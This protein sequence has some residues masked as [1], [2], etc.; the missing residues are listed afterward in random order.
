MRL[1]TLLTIALLA[2][3]ALA[4]AGEPAARPQLA[5]LDFEARNVD[6]LLA[7]SLTDAVAGALREL[8]VFKVV[9]QSEI[10]Q[11]L[12]LEH[13]R[14]LLTTCDDASCIAQIGA[15]VG[16]R[17]VVAGQV[18]ALEKNKGPLSLRLRLFDMKKAEVQS[19]ET[20][21]KLADAKEA[22]QAAPALALSSVRPILDKEQGFL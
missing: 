7:Q 10:R 18:V 21:S 4:T 16:A 2:A 6:P 20:R 17:F 12:A 3:P 14:S 5:V 13:D 15:A 11:M 1:T 9:S 8:R 22:L 19:D